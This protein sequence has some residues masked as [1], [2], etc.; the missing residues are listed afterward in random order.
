MTHVKIKK[1]KGW[2]SNQTSRQTNKLTTIR[3]VMFIIILV[4]ARIAIINKRWGSKW[5]DGETNN[6]IE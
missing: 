1:E 4:V 2:A 5:R 3:N 6:L